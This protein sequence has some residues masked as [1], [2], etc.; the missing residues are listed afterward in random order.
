MPDAP[1]VGDQHER[2]GR[3]AVRAGSRDDIDGGANARDDGG[4]GE[5]GQCDQAAR[6]DRCDSCA[7]SGTGAD[8]D[9][10]L[11]P[12]CGS[13]V[14]SA[15]RRQSAKGGRLHCDEHGAGR[16]SKG[17]PGW[18]AD[19][20]GDCKGCERCELAGFSFIS[21]GLAAAG[22]VGGCVSA[23]ICGRDGAGASGWRDVGRA[24]RAEHERIG[25]AA[26]AVPNGS[27]GW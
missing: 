8:L 23:G 16:G 4:E 21:A 5:R 25:R 12:E 22:G 1:A 7:G 10:E 15:G 14:Q 27:T 2:N 9:G 19:R 11:Q 24:D 18:D 6:S 13:A 20:C 17:G 3:G 26:A